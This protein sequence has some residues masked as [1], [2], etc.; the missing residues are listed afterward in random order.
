[1]RA[2]S[3]W[4]LME[5]LERVTLSSNRNR[6]KNLSG[7]GLCRN[8]SNH[9]Q[10]MKKDHFTVSPLRFPSQG[11]TEDGVTMTGFFFQRKLTFLLCES[12]DVHLVFERFPRYKERGSAKSYW[13]L[14]NFTITNRDQKNDHLFIILRIILFHCVHEM[15]S[16]VCLEEMSSLNI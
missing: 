8:F 5:L 16:F 12:S 4:F 11:L 2:Q 3:T 1:M 7:F 13:A 10:P 6:S 9:Q 14:N 15:W